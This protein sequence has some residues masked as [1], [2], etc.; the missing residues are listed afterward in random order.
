MKAIIPALV[1]LMSCQ[2]WS[3]VA[4]KESLSIATQ[5]YSVHSVDFVT[6]NDLLIVPV[7]IDGQTYRFLFDTGSPTLISSRLAKHLNVNKLKKTKTFDSQGN[8]R[9][10]TYVT[11]AELGI[12]N[13]T[14]EH[15]V[16]GVVDFNQTSAIACLK[17]DGVIGTNIMNL[18]CWQI[19]YATSKIRIAS[20]AHDLL[21]RSPVSLL[22]RYCFPFY[23]DMNGTPNLTLKIGSTEV[24]NLKMDTGSVSFLSIGKEYI[25]PLTSKGEIVAQRTAYGSHLVGLFGSA[26]KDTIKQALIKYVSIG[27]QLYLSHQV[28][29]FRPTK[30]SLMGNAFLRNFIVTIDFNNNTII[31]EANTTFDNDFAKSFGISLQKENNKTI[32]SMVTQGSD[33]QASGIQVGDTVLKMNDID[34]TTTSLEA[35]CQVIHLIRSKEIEQIELV[36][37]NN[38]TKNTT[39]IAKMQ[40]LSIDAH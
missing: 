26:E 19:D 16:A 2:Q 28:I 39:V 3:K 15:V 7:R 17:I 38:G 25:D 13:L 27:D 4:S 24:K 35:Y 40:A 5:Q 6:V 36:W 11:L 9:Q 34:L 14:F 32:V 33:A 21:D 12:E 20:H 23:V 37:T 31:L 30:L 10:I 29:D 22:D 8:A 18:A 1:L